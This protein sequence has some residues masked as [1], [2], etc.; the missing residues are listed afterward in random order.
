VETLVREVRYAIRSLLHA[1]GFTAVA[2]ITLAVGIGATTA[3][4]SVVNA[5]L[6]RPL[7]FHDPQQLV[8]VSESDSRYGAPAPG[9]GTF[10]YP[11]FEDVRARS[12]NLHA[13]AFYSSSLTMTEG[14]QAAHVQVET[15][16]AS[17]FDLLGVSPSLGRGF[18]DNEDQAGPYVAVLSDR[19]WRSHFN[20]DRDVLGKTVD[21]NGVAV[22]I[23]GVMPQ[24]FQF[25]IRAKP[26]DL[27]FT[28]AHYLEQQ[29]KYPP[30]RQRDNHHLGAI[31]RLRPGVTREQANAEMASLARALAGEYPDSNNTMDIAVRPELEFIVGDTRTPLMILFAAVS[32]VLLIA[33]ANVANLLLA[34]STGRAREI[35]L[36]LAIGA[37]RSRIVRQLVTESLVLA[38]VGAAAGIVVAYGALSGVLHLYPSNLPRAEDIGIDLRV[39]LF[40]TAIALLTGI[41]FGLAP[42]LHIS[43]PDLTE[44]MREGGRTSTAGPGQN[45]LR[46]T[47][48]VAETAL[49]VMLVIVAGLLVRSFQRLSHANLG[50]NPTGLVTARFDLSETR[51]THDLSDRFVGE[52]FNRLRV[53]PG[54]VSASGTRPLPLYNDVYASTFDLVDHPAPKQNLPTSGF[55]LV[56]PGYFETMQIPLISGRT[57]DQRDRRDSLPVAIITQEFARR[58]FPDENPIGKRITVEIAEAG[59]ENY[60][61]REIV[62]VVG[63]IRR[64]DLRAAP[65]PSYYLP[66]PQLMS[67]PPTLVLRT[68]T[69]SDSLASEVRKV[70]S[71]MDPEIALYDARSMED[72]LA[73]DL[74]LARFQ[75]ALLTVFAGIALFLTAVGLYGVIAYVVGQRLHEFGVRQAL[76]ATRKDVLWLVMEH[77]IKLVLAGVSI[78][79]AG[80]LALARFVAALLYEVPSRDPL[81]YLIACV[82]L[83]SVGLLAS[84]IPAL[85]ATRVD[86]LVVLRYE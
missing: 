40:T 36:R 24:G 26:I 46:S 51:Y 42:A 54:V 84:Y 59:R 27:W 19:F 57:F 17:L 86:P 56:V 33:C 66:L 1:G 60:R 30:A 47:L 6:L 45:R 68:S 5:V 62:G 81:S 41:L 12:R 11:D 15:V 78:G 69:G 4:F 29:K 83:A 72:Y 10:S 3:M 52:L 9:G 43:K 22:S 8:D 37:S 7:P 48:V 23:V 63:D 28:F 73:L 55:Y 49:G 20:A 80:A 53:L 2:I 82:A 65:I 39:L 21:L 85:R 31:A 34:R 77:G 74:G 79:I 76:G 67:G 58:Y 61:T 16:S 25:P 38:L 50:F 18:T 71:G 32:L 44:N 14:L 13:A 70:L 75:T 64:T 35:A